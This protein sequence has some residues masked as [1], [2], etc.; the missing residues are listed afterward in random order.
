VSDEVEGILALS[1]SPEHE[2]VNIGNPCEFT[3]L[4]CA[5]MVVEV[6]GSRSRVRF[7]PLPRD[8]PRQRRPDI[9]KAR[10]LLGWEPRIDLRTGLEMS[11]EY[12]RSAVGK[13]AAAT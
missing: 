3:I 2:P 1:K 7:E 13:T 11:L 10:H 9:S 8:D 5:Q 12:F 4:Q 6:T